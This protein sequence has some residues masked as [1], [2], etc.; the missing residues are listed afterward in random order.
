MDTPS[1]ITQMISCLIIVKNKSG[2]SLVLAIPKDSVPIATQLKNVNDGTLLDLSDI[3]AIQNGDKL[4]LPK[5][6]T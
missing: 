2:L 5:R 4:L 1:F 3:L 6:P